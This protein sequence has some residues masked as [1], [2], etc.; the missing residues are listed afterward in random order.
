MTGFIITPQDTVVP[1]ENAIV[2]RHSGNE[3]SRYKYKNKTVRSVRW[4]EQP[5]VVL[6][7]VSRVLRSSNPSHLASYLPNNRKTIHRVDGRYTLVVDE[8]GT[9][10]ILHRSVCTEAAEFEQWLSANVFSP[11]HEKVGNMSSDHVPTSEDSLATIEV[12]GTSATIQA[13]LLDGKPMVALKP[14]CEALGIDVDGQRRKLKNKTWAVTELISATGA[15]GKTYQMVMIDRRTMTGWLF[16]IDENRVAESARDALR[17]FQTEAADALD[18]YFHEGGAVNPHATV[19]QLDTIIDRAQEQKE[20]RLDLGRRQLEFLRVAQG[21]IPTAHIEARAEIIV[22]RT[23]G[24]VPD[25][26]PDALPL[27]VYSFLK[28]KGCNRKFMIS[29]SAAFGTRMR[30][31]FEAER[32]YTP[33]KCQ[34]EMPDGKIRGAYA[35]T[36]A[37]RPIMEKVWLQA[38]ADRPELWQ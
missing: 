19:E 16:T 38:Y 12:P 1:P 25:I 35:Y 21:L 34:Q 32:G 37:D 3:V 10:E 8:P 22:A 13:T 31:A 18:A 36:E 23:L 33:E 15:D 17:A 7:D 14:M 27:Y 24:E 30:A 28:E 26:A 29:Y 2:P 6:A 5:A 9:Y 4:D 11:F 20:D